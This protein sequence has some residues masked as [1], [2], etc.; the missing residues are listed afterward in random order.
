MKPK[1]ASAAP[2]PASKSPIFFRGGRPPLELKLRSYL[3]EEACYELLG[4][5]VKPRIE[6]ENLDGSRFAEGFFHQIQDGRLTASPRA[7]EAD[8]EPRVLG[9]A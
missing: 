1:E 3:I 6:V 9:Q 4:A 7:D 5:G 8:G 2:Y